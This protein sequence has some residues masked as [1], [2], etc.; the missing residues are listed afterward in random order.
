MRGTEGEV[1]KKRF[2]GSGRGM[3]SG[4]GANMIKIHYM[5]EVT[6]E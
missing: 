3:G 4:N 1:G 2:N 5:P 6:K